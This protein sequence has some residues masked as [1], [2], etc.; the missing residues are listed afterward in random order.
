[1]LSGESFRVFEFAEADYNI[2]AIFEES[3]ILTGKS[4]KLEYPRAIDLICSFDIETSVV[5]GMDESIMYVWQ[6]AIEDQ[7]VIIGRTWDEFRRFLITIESICL[8]LQ[9]RLIIFVHNLS[10]EFQFLRTVLEFTE[11][12][13]FLI[14]PRKPLTA[15]YHD[16]I[17]FRCS[18]FLSNMSLQE[19]TKKMKVKHPKQDGD[20]YDYEK[21]RYPWDELSED[22][23]RYCCYDV[24]GLNEAIRVLM[25]SEQDNLIS[26]P[27]TSTGYVR[28]DARDAMRQVVKGYVSDQLP[29]YY[30]Y[31]MCREAFRGG[32]THANR[33]YVGHILENVYSADRSSSYPDV[34]CN[35]LFPVS[36]FKNAGEVTSSYLDK[37]LNHEKALLIR[38]A[39]WNVQLR[40]VYWGSPYIPI[41]KCRH[42]Y[43]YAPDNGRVLNAE[44]LEIT[45]TD[46]DFKIIEAEYKWDRL[47]ILDV[48]SASYGPLPDALKKITIQ[49]YRN[50]TSLKGVKNQEIFYTKEKNK[51]NSIYG[52]SAQ[53]PVKQSIKMQGLDYVIGTEDEEHILLST[54]SQQF[55][56]YQWGVWVTAWARYRLEEGIRL[57]GDDFV[58]TDTDCVKSLSEIDF[59]AYN[60]IRQKASKASGAYAK[61]PSGKTHYM[62]VYETEEKADRFITWG[63]KK[64]VTEKDG[65]VNVTVS[66]VV[67]K[68]SA[69]EL[70][71]L[72]GIE[73]FK[74]GLVFRDAGGLEAVYNDHPL[75]RL[76]IDGKQ[77]ELPSNTC[78]LPSEYTL[79]IT[80]QYEELLFSIE[81]SL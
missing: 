39:F 57:A 29:D 63:S 16:I 34:Q 73:A 81:N 46:I 66:G 35:D 74:P 2:Y 52:M 76:T 47:E 80:S 19:F 3:E 56:P 70:E 64:Y 65:K 58:Y 6:F 17:E 8:D 20:D 37:L 45:L 1:M 10:Y 77:I 55:M 28:R 72:G 21:T 12:Q 24:I 67:R 31:Q 14:K 25:E 48:S 38:A 51:L 68:H 61:D 7:L 44:Y 42:M 43:D 41:D 26:L 49:Y 54:R 59:S 33:Y 50:K 32:N 60:K 71:K 78:L 18:Y 22:E 11:D 30:T 36:A 62:G 13:V 15:R 27:H 40:N 69:G 23:L 5:K 4:R 75:Q 79:G 53:N 9:A